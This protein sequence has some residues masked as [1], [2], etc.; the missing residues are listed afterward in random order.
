MDVLEARRSTTAMQ[1]MEDRAQWHTEEQRKEVVQSRVSEV[2]ERIFIIIE[3]SIDQARFSAVY[4][5]SERVSNYRKNNQEVGET[6]LF[7]RDVAAEVVRNL[8]AV[9]FWASIVNEQEE[10]GH[11][12]TYNE[13]PE[14]YTS[15][16][17]IDWSPQEPTVE[18]LF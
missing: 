4:E 16:I 5:Y 9:G 12:Q 15:T 2:L 17:E 11:D 13:P 3:D 10:P 8:K 18:T 7:A 1:E 14:R 6:I